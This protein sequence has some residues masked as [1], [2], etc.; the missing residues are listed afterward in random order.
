MLKPWLADKTPGSPVFTMREDTAAKVIRTD[1][2]PAGIDTAGVD[3]HALRHSYITMLV[4]SGASVKVCQ[5]LARHADPKLT[6]NFY[7]T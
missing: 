2:E 6:M 7:T 1:L 5:E 3:F 4:K